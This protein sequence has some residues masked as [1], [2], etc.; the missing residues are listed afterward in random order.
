MTLEGPQSE[1]FE[2]WKKELQHE[3]D[4]GAPLRDTFDELPEEEEIENS[5]TIEELQKK[6]ATL[7]D[8][9]QR[10]N[11]ELAWHQGK[12]KAIKKEEDI[13]EYRDEQIEGLL[14]PWIFD[15]EYTSPLLVSYDRKINDLENELK[16]SKEEFES[17]Q[18]SIQSVTEENNSLHDKLKKSYRE[19]IAQAESKNSAGSYGE[20]EELLQTYD[21]RLSVLQEENEVLIQQQQQLTNE[22]KRLKSE[23]KNLNEQS[24]K[25]SENSSRA[26]S[27]IENAKNKI[28]NQ[29]SEINRLK[30]K[31]SQSQAQMNAGYGEKDVLEE[32][33][34]QLQNRNK[35]LQ[36]SNTNSQ[37]IIDNLKLNLKQ[38]TNHINDLYYQVD[39]KDKY[40]AE[41]EGRI[42][43]LKK[44]TKNIRNRNSSLEKNMADLESR[45]VSTQQSEFEGL[46]KIKETLETL[47][48]TKIERDHAQAVGEGNGKEIDRLRK[49]LRSEVSD[50]ENRHKEDTS[51]IEKKYLQRINR[52]SQD[53]EQTQTENTKINSINERLEREKRALEDQYKKLRDERENEVETEK[54]IQKLGHQITLANQERDDAS[55]TVEEM[56]TANKKLK[57]QW[58][59]DHSNLQ[60]KISLLEQQVTNLESEKHDTQNSNNELKQ[61]VY[62]LQAQIQN[63]GQEKKF[64]SSN[65]R[66]EMEIQ[67]KNLKR[68]VEEL[69]NE[70][71]DALNAKSDAENRANNYNSEIRRTRM[72][73]EEQMNTL[74]E[75]QEENMKELS[76]ERDEILSKNQQLESDISDLYAKLSIKE[77]T[78]EETKKEK[79]R[80]SYMYRVLQQRAD[81]QSGQISSLLNKQAELLSQKE[82][83]HVQVDRLKLDVERLHRERDN[84][85]WTKDIRGSLMNK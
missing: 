4:I 51:A 25:M 64:G 63:L 53:L 16:K 60:N 66:Q 82:N 73:M 19:S 32:Q 49:K 7:S 3:S 83:L 14:P 77:A 10:L 34:T 5:A 69:E 47:E 44:E 11:E 58:N 39:N 81:N 84:F 42:D 27:M 79:D 30:E 56:R 38:K 2:K 26:N 21:Q 59:E 78:S 9:V 45:L 23:N 70:L 15:A 24:N 50:L 43:F 29:E 76:K 75:T 74:Q 54:T 62:K 65:L 36:E 6:C 80:I 31:L 17:L 35:S 55:N 28:N 40:I 12:L 8:L 20:H 52:L 68:K 85:K 71:R 13:E 57:S 61:Q 41:L 48:N 46:R 22:I 33:V 1:R 72:K 37:Q 18:K 67:V